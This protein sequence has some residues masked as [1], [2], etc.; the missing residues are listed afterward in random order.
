MTDIDPEKFRRRCPMLGGEVPLAY[1]EQCAEGQKIC[2]KIF[3]CWWERFD[4]VGYLERK[5][6]PE[7]YEGLIDRR[8]QSKISSILACIEKARSGR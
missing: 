1:C 2:P 3:N 5:L 6:P 7:E 4:V 8:P